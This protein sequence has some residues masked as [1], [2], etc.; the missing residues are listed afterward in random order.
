M[1]SQYRSVIDAGRRK[2]FEVAKMITP[3]SARLF[4]NKVRR[5]A[6]AIRLTRQERDPLGVSRRVHKLRILLR[7]R[8][9]RQLVH[10]PMALVIPRW[11]RRGRQRRYQGC[12]GDETN[13]K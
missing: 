6:P 3:A 8:R 2:I 1:I 12:A 7:Q 10:D 4:Q 5:I 11:E 13:R 9:K